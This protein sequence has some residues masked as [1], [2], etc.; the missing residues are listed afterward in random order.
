MITN[1]KKNKTYFHRKVGFMKFLRKNEDGNYIFQDLNGQ[2]VTF[3]PEGLEEIYETKVD[4]KGMKFDYGKVKWSLIPWEELEEVVQ[5]LTYGAKKYSDDNWKKVEDLETTAFNAAMRHL[6]AYLKDKTE[7]K[8]SIDK[9][10]NL[11]HLAHAT[12]NLLFLM[13][14]ERNRK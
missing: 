2:E 10:S 9:E 12:A 13:W 7:N 6:V 4:N 5:V 3:L 1:L 11:R 8:I 14:A